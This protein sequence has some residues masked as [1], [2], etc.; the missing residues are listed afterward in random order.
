[1][2]V[3]NAV[4]YFGS[5]IISVKTVVIEFDQKMKGGG[6]KENKGHMDIFSHRSAISD[7][8]ENV[9]VFLPCS[10]RLFS[11]GDSFRLPR[12]S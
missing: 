12:E 9:F 4:Y 11:I 7:V 1:M 5:T 8:P 3:L 2:S 6:N 10:F